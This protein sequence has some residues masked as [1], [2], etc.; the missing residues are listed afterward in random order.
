MLKYYVLDST[1]ACFMVRVFPESTILAISSASSHMFLQRHKH[2][3]VWY[4]ELQAHYNLMVILQF[5]KGQ[6]SAYSQST[7]TQVLSIPGE[8]VQT[9]FSCNGSFQVM[10]KSYHNLSISYIISIFKYTC[11]MYVKA[12]SVGPSWRF[13]VSLVS[14]RLHR[15]HYEVVPPLRNHLNK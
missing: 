12:L 2:R 14:Y 15:K 7:R 1:A 3:Q 10:M 8:A 6:E 5:E 4:N 9:L 13:I 11:Y